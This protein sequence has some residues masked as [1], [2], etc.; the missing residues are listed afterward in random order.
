MHCFEIFFETVQVVRVA[1]SVLGCEKAA[2]QPT[3]NLFH[4]DGQAVCNTNTQI[5][6]LD[7]T[8]MPGPAGPSGPAGA[9]GPTGS[10]GLPGPWGERGEVGALGV[11]GK[12][13]IGPPGM[14]GLAG[15][16]GIPGTPGTPGPPGHSGAPGTPGTP[17]TPGPPGPDGPVCDFN[18]G[19]MLSHFYNTV[20][21]SSFLLS[22]YSYAYWEHPNSYAQSNIHILSLTQPGTA[23]D[24]ADGA[25]CN[26][27]HPYQVTASLTTLQQRLRN[28]D[29]ATQLESHEPVAFVK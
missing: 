18:F 22:P 17:G 24:G 10:A 6:L 7:F 23:H 4:N 9:V 27:W 3:F 26:D 1:R 13:V 16:V 5:T 11:P 28:K 21:P 12:Y 25:S 15:P 29:C 2:F 14:N 19:S 8:G 20:P